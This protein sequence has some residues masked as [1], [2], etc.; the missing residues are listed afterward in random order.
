[1]D[2]EALEP[3]ILVRDRFDAIDDLRGRAAEPGLLLDAITQ[4]R[5]PRGRAGRA[6]GASLL[7]GIAY[8]AERREPLVAF[9]VRR[10]EPAD[11][12]LP[13]WREVDAGAP[14]HVLAE[15]LRLAVSLA[16]G[17]IGA[18]DVVEDLFAVEG[19]HRLEAVARHHVDG[20]AACDRHPDV[21]RQM[22]RPRDHGDV[23]KAIAAMVDRRR[24]LIVLALVADGTLVEA[25]E[26]QL[27]L[28]LEQLAIGVGVKKRRAEGFHFAR[29][30]AATDAH[31]DAPVGHDVGHRVVFGQPDGMPH[32]QHIEGA[33]EL[34]PLGLG[35]EPQPELDQVGQAFVAL[36][37]EVMLRRPQHVVAE[38]V[39][40]LRDIARGRKSLP[41]AL[42]GITPIVGRRAGYSD[43]VELD[44][45]DIEDVQVP[46]HRAFPR[47]ALTVEQT[48]VLGSCRCGWLVCEALIQGDADGNI[49]HPADLASTA[50]CRAI[51]N[52]GS[53]Y[54]C[55]SAPGTA[56]CAA[57]R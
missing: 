24:A 29:M 42:V 34:E 15:L 40:M 7:V 12:F 41:Q 30:V 23:L 33:A 13:A 11:G 32:R 50:C 54:P 4:R 22:Q 46:N 3:G 1:M 36:A 43:I 16:G 45:T 18:H 14:D 27:E 37:L 38:A 51:R 10:L 26:Q 56:A 28:L 52:G 21:D 19:Y 6:P 35:R 9:V 25:F 47:S 44:L 20:L 2:H 31:D 48:F 57:A 49:R 39:H 55:R 17:V 53:T 5:D 8:E